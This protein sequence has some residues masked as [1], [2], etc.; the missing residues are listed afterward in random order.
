MLQAPLLS[1]S[2]DIL[3]IPFG[4]INLYE[5]SLPLFAMSFNDLKRFFL[6]AKWDLPRRDHLFFDAVVFYLSEGREG[7]AFPTVDDE[8]PSSILSAFLH[9][10]I[11]LPDMSSEDWGSFRCG[12]NYLYYPKQWILP[13]WRWI[14]VYK[15]QGTEPLDMSAIL[16]TNDIL[17]P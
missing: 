2:I 8:D 10:T 9:T 3:H 16:E 13:Q 12:R 1:E 17:S 5:T 15:L 14:R 4:S 11:P 7:T 6:C